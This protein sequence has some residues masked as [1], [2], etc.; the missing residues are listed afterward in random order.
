M[1]KTVLLGILGLA[2]FS[3]VLIPVY[4]CFSGFASHPWTEEEQW[5][6][7]KKIMMLTEPEEA[8]CFGDL[9]R[10]AWGFRHSWRQRLINRWGRG[11]GAPKLELSEGFKERVI[12]IAESD[13]D[14]QSLL[15]EGYNV[16]AIKPIHVKMTVQEDGQVV[17]EVDRVLLILTK[18]KYN[19][20]IVVIDF[21]AEEVM[22][23]IIVNVT[24]INK[25][26]SP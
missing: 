12:E 18:D 2:V 11:I 17:A 8:P 20:A 4:A 9:R 6:G 10:F 7:R 16:T 23:I 1:N 5:T 24:M 3:A 19:R 13:G 15:S 26:E 21:K 25:T 22:K 14:V